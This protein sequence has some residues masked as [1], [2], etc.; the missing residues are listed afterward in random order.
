[1]TEAGQCFQLPSRLE[2]MAVFSACRIIAWCSDSLRAFAFSKYCSCTTTPSASV[3]SVGILYQKPRL[4]ELVAERFPEEIGSH[5]YS[6]L[7]IA[8]IAARSLP[9]VAMHD[10]GGR[11]REQPITKIYALR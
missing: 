3:L 9:S 8:G 7:H 1:M 2:G 11:S 10:L 6:H 4:K 5:F